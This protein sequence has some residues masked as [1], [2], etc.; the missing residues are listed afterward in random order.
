[1]T[2]AAVHLPVI[3]P[4]SVCASAPRPCPWTECR[5][6]FEPARASDWVL[7]APSCAIDVADRVRE[8][9][10][11]PEQQHIA[12]WFGVSRS[13]IHQL[14]AAGLSKLL[15]HAREVGL[16]VVDELEPDE[17]PEDLVLGLLRRYREG[18]THRQVVEALAMPRRSAR[19]ALE[20][21]EEMG[22]AM[23]QGFRPAVWRIAR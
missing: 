18:L 14:E 4:R 23:K 2:A 6:R 7:P 20:R 17:R 1:M 12:D 16:P 8:G 3:P 5:H 11:P 10:D 21:L 13:R 19:Q 22:H 9:D 15:A